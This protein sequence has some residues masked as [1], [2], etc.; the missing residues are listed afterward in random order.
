MDKHAIW[1]T[2]LLATC[3]VIRNSSPIGWIP[4]LLLKCLEGGYF[5]TFLRTL[6]MFGLPIIV[7]SIIFDSFFYGA[8][9]WVITWLNFLRVNLLYNLSAYFGLDP[10][11]HYVLIVLPKV[12]HISL[13][14]LIFG[15][16][17][18]AREQQEMKQPPYLII[19]SLFYLFMMSLIPHKEDRFLMPIFPAFFIMI[20]RAVIRHAETHPRIVRFYLYLLLVI[21]IV[22]LYI[23]TNYHKRSWEGA[24]WIAS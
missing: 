21:E 16:C 20:G 17:I 8:D 1:L 6:F 15:F 13:V 5:H 24:K 12:F 10:I 14:P 23:F 19:F 11:Y 2:I 7:F 3:F 4:L 18:Y 9:S 22:T